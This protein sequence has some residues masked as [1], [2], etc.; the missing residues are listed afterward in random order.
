MLKVLKKLVIPFTINE[1]KANIVLIIMT[2]V[3]SVT[4]YGTQR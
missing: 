3:A 2:V 4:T 1:H